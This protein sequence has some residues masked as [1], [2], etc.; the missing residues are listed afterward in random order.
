MQEVDL[1]ATVTGGKRLLDLGDFIEGADDEKVFLKAKPVPGTYTTEWDYFTVGG[2]N[3]MKFGTGISLTYAYKENYAWRLFL[4][5]DYTRKTY[6]MTYNPSMFAFDAISLGLGDE[7]AS[8]SDLLQGEDLSDLME[9]QS[10]KKNRHTFILGG[11]LV[12][13]F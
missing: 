6:T 4:D 1:N 8:F 2:N 12:I 11:S 9:R 3:T 5:Y 10:I 7:S 13:S